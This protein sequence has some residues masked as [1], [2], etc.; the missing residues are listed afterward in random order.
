VLPQ[1]D[2][3]DEVEKEDHLGNNGDDEVTFA[4]L[5]V[6]EPLVKA[7]IAMKWTVRMQ[8]W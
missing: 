4:S 2:A 7:A 6:A 5:G 8:W 3:I 1:M